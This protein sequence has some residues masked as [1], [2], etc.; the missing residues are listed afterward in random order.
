MDAESCQPDAAIH[1]WFHGLAEPRHTSRVAEVCHP[2]R[3]PLERSLPL[4]A[5]WFKRALVFPP[6]WRPSCA[7]GLHLA[8]DPKG[9]KH[10]SDLP[11]L[12]RN[13][14]A[15]VGATVTQADH[16]SV[17]SQRSASLQLAPVRRL[18]GAFFAKARATCGVQPPE[19]GGSLRPRGRNAHIANAP[20]T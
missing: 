5:R 19:P 17:S 18:S 2:I 4:E 16:A 3:L 13:S 9:A 11:Y 6:D 8:Q 10:P 1:T 20:A 15:D 7:N 12:Q 14:F